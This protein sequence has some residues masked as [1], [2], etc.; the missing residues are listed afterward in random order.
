MEV[1]KRR[2]VRNRNAYRFQLKL[3]PE[4]ELEEFV[5]SDFNDGKSVQEIADELFYAGISLDEFVYKEVGVDD[6]ERII[7]EYIDRGE[8]TLVQVQLEERYP[9]M[10][11]RSN[12]GESAGLALMALAG[13]GLLAWGWSRRR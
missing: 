4:E 10:R 3:T 2:K 9:N 12:P 6:V 11:F 13:L 1:L 5:V 8:R 7:D